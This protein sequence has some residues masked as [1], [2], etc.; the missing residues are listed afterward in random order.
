MSGL[1]TNEWWHVQVEL[2]FSEDDGLPLEVYSPRNEVVAL[3]FILQLVENS[4]CNCTELQ[5]GDL[6][7]LR[8]SIIG[9]IGNIQVE[10]GIKSVIVED[11]CCEKEHCLLQWGEDN[12]VK[13]RLRIAC[14]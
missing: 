14:K 9:K 3:N 4:L 10:D 1:A 12:G 8:T 7:E 5:K 11:Q 6:Q 13:T 2:Y